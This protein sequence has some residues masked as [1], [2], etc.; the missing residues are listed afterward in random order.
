[1]DQLDPPD[2]AQVEFRPPHVVV[3]ADW[4]RRRRHMDEF[5]MKAIAVALF[6]LFVNTILDMILI[7]ER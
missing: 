1:M 6:L 4:V 3:P 2:Q 5:L 7:L